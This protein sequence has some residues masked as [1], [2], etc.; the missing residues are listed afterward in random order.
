MWLCLT[1][2]SQ[3]GRTFNDKNVKVKFVLATI[4]LEQHN[5]AIIL[6]C[7]SYLP[8]LYISSNHFVYVCFFVFEVNIVFLTAKLLLC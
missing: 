6:S 2:I 8:M 5:R 3:A 1:S 4:V 7:S